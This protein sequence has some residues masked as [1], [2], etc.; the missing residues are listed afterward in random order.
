MPRN[1]RQFSDLDLNFTPH[2][3]TKDIALVYDEYAI[4]TA[5]KN[6][7][8]TNNYERPFHSEIG[9]PIRA[10]LFDLETPLLAVSLKKVISDLIHNHEP[11][12]SLVDIIV[13]SIPEENSVNITIVF[14]ILNTTRPITLDLVLERTR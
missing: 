5:V 14:T 13:D 2:P 6:L 3:V 7:V 8:L 11:R 4:K 12:V 9:S 10:L 1:T